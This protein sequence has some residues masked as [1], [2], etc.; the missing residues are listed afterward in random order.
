M[1][2]K[3]SGAAY[4]V[5]VSVVILL[6]Y[7]QALSYRLVGAQD[8]VVSMVYPESQE[9]LCPDQPVVFQCQFLMQTGTL[10]W[11]FLNEL[12][13]RYLT[14]EDLVVGNTKSEGQFTANVTGSMPGALTGFFLINS[15]LTVQPALDDLN[16]TVVECEGLTA[17]RGLRSNTTN[18]ILSG[19]P[20]PPR[21][22]NL[23]TA[24]GKLI[25]LL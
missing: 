5:P 3:V 8:V 17:P 2:G 14:E 9:R 6:L 22:V 1:I 7:S 23:T 24:Q 13:I 18:I 15:T 4:K 10:I 11:R 25:H 19:S 21:D 16:S 12:P 20:S